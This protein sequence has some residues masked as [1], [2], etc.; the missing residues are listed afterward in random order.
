MNFKEIILKETGIDITKKCRKK[1]YIEMKACTSYV[2]RKMGFQYTE[3]GKY[4]NLDH[5]TIIHHIKIYDAMR[6]SSARV[7]DMEDILLGKSTTASKEVKRLEEI[8]YNQ[9]KMINNLQMQIATVENNNIKRLIPLLKN[10]DI[11]VKFN[12]FVELNEKAKFYPKF[13]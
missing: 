7:Q 9:K 11:E 8:I 1:E 10:K 5:S 3:I 2:M 13:N 12:A 4:M 6:F